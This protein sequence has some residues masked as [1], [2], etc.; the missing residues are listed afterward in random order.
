MPNDP[1]QDGNFK[2]P[3]IGEN[4]WDKWKFSEIP[5]DDLFWFQD[6]NSD[7]NVPHRKMSET[8]GMNLRTRI[9]VNIDPNEKVFMRI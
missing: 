2:T 3:G 9:N 6:N 8:E 5:V 1:A 4:D 7:S